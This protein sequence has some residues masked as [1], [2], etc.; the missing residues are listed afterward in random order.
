MARRV[1]LILADLIRLTARDFQHSSEGSDGWE[2]LAAI[3]DEIREFGDVEVFAPAMFDVMERL[4]DVELGT[5][6][7]L[8]HTLEQCPG[9]YERYL[10]ESVRRKPARLTVWMINRILNAKPPDSRDWIRLLREVDLHALASKETKAAAK[11]Y[12]ERQ[13]AS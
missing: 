2:R 13:G 5:P 4:D 11:G 9:K 10:A 3:C 12:L 1:N 7:P 8:V 6:G